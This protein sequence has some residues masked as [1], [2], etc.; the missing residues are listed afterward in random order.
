MPLIN[1]KYLDIHPTIHLL[2]F[3]LFIV[4]NQVKQ[5]VD[6]VINFIIPA[7]YRQSDREGFQVT[8]VVR[9]AVANQ[10]RH[11]LKNKEA[12]QAGDGKPPMTEG[13]IYRLLSIMK[14]GA[15]NFYSTMTFISMAVACGSRSGSLDKLTLDDI[16]KI[17][18]HPEKLIT[19]GV[20]FRYAKKKQGNNQ[21]EISFS[22]LTDIKLNQLNVV[23]NLSHFLKET[24]NLDLAN[25]KDWKSDPLYDGSNLIFQGIKGSTMSSRLNLWMTHVGYPNSLFSLHSGRASFLCNGVFEAMAQGNIYIYIYIYI[26]VLFI[27]LF[28]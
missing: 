23:Y 13:D 11:N 2:L 1:R 7:L 28:I 25:L 14:P 10:S 5:A 27:F 17:K 9:D 16:F 6:S 24:F 21:T 26:N 20:R 15:N 3:G 18:V 8:Q 4:S 12:R 19:I 22:G